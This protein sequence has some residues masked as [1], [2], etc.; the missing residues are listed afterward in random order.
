[1]HQMKLMN[2]ADQRTVVCGFSEMS[3]R[4]GFNANNAV[5]RRYQLRKSLEKT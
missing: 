2:C 3:Y 1:M 5:Q 4:S